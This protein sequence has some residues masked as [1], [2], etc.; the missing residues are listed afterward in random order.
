[1][2]PDDYNEGLARMGIV[3]YERDGVPKSIEKILG[4][5]AHWFT[6]PDMS[7]TE[8][9][10]IGDQYLKIGPG[11]VEILA[12]G[13]KNAMDMIAG[14]QK[15]GLIPTDKDIQEERLQGRL[16][17]FNKAKTYT[18]GRKGITSL[19]DLLTGT[20][21]ETLGTS[22]VVETFDA[23]LRNGP[24]KT[25]GQLEGR[26]DKYKPN[27]FKEMFGYKDSFFIEQGKM[28]LLS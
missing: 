24:E 11:T 9:Y 7:M 15:S 25:F 21:A 22:G 6:R 27:Q 2:K 3:P 18:A 4:E 20:I 16:A 14:F 8:K 1:M 23:I 12:M 19:T 17:A 5:I 28:L 10:R 26:I 13:W